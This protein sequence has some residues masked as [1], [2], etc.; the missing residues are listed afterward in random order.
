MTN[1]VALTVGGA[2]ITAGLVGAAAPQQLGSL[3]GLKDVSPDL[4]LLMRLYGLGNAAL[5]INMA[6]AGEAE[7]RKLLAVAALIDGLSAAAAIAAP[8]S[9]RTKAMLVGTFAPI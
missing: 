9:G 2:A 6:T 5:G 3:F 1:H 7:R 4:A 8:V